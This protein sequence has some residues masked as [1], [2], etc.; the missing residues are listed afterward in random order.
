[1][2]HI[3]YMVKKEFASKTDIGLGMNNC[4]WSFNNGVY[5]WWFRS[6]DIVVAV[7]CS[8]CS[9]TFSG[10]SWL[11]NVHLCEWYRKQNA[12]AFVN[13]FFFFPNPFWAARSLSAS[14]SISLPW[15]F[16]LTLIPM[17]VR[18]SYYIYHHLLYIFF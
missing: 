5:L 13:T 12:F 2:C 11:I 6:K 4:H 15:F 14:V 7:C 1:M 18:C 8:V 16:I 9:F 17:F 10:L 3:L